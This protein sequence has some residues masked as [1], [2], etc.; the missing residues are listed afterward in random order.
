MKVFKNNRE[1]FVALTDILP[2]SKT[3]P[4][5]RLMTEK[6]DYFK[7]TGKE[8][9]KSVVKSVVKESVKPIKTKAFKYQYVAPLEVYRLDEESNKQLDST[10]F[11]KAIKDYHG[12]NNI[13]HFIC[14]KDKNW[15][16]NWDDTQNIKMVIKKTNLVITFE[17]K[18][19]LD[20]YQIAMIDDNI[21]GG[22]SDGWG[23]SIENA[24]YK[25]AKKKS[26]DVVIGGG[27]L[28]EVV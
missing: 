21:S 13:T 23:A 1:S 3:D 5:R 22:I 4:E 25:D 17:T 20:M 14:D 11:M 10:K 15:L 16:T 26:F 6:D 12:G 28:V 24:K 27:D 18:N 19:K 2:R 7:N 9:I 8:S